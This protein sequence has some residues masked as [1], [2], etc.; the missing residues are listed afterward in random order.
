MTQI[1]G[2]LVDDT[3]VQGEKVIIELPAVDLEKIKVGDEIWIRQEVKE[4]KS[5]VLY[6]VNSYVCAGHSINPA[7]QND[8]TAYLAQK[9]DGLE[10]IIKESSLCHLC[11]SNVD[12]GE[13]EVKELVNEIRKHLEVER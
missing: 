4:T 12:E 2:K 11:L 7:R 10:G 9:L 8:F 13:K 1:S 6:V 5:T 3:A